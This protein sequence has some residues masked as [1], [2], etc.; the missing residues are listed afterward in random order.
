MSEMIRGPYR[1]E[2]GISY[3]SGGRGT[4]LLVLLHGL[5]SNSAVWQPMLQWVDREWEGPW[6]A[7]DFSG[8][9]SSAP[10]E[11]YSY[12]AYA[13][14]I[15]QLTAGADRISILGH[16]MGGAVAMKLAAIAP[17][18]LVESI[19]ALSV[20][21]AFTEDEIRF[22]QGRAAAE[23]AYLDSATEAKQ[24]YLKVSGLAGLV[25]TGSEVSERGIAAGDRGYRLAMD[26]KAFGIAADTLPSPNAATCKVMLATGSEDRI[27]PPNE[28]RRLFADSIVLE[29][30]GHN[31][32]VQDPEKVWRNLSPFLGPA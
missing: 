23:V 4:H 15:L 30:L 20:K 12:E 3:L 14:E 25:D 32:H 13:R 28:M 9:G 6:I 18:R 16:S 7:P 26:P 11:T 5:G 19:A 21:L 29:G 2:S 1:T 24:R 8:H 10:C 22:F 31:A 17:P 27:A